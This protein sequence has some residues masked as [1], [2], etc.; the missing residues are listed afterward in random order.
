MFGNLVAHTHAGRRERE[1]T[2]TLV[3]LG[4]DGERFIPQSD[5]FLAQVTVQVKLKTS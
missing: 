3:L 2:G 4:L 1:S 5:A